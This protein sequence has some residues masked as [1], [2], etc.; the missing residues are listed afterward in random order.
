MVIL[1]LVHAPAARLIGAAL[2]ANGRVITSATALCFAASL[3]KERVDVVIVDPSV[4]PTRTA[5]R[6]GANPIV[7]SLS[8]AAAPPFIIYLSDGRA[9]L[10]LRAALV[11]LRPAMVAARGIDDQPERIRAMVD[12]AVASRT[13]EELVSRLDDR[14]ALVRATLGDALADAVRCPLECDSV[15]ALALA[16]GMS[17][18]ALSRELK[19]AG[20]ASARDWLAA[21]RVLRAHW[22]LRDPALRIRHLVAIM[23]YSSEEPLGNDVAAL[24][25]MTPSELRR[26]SRAELVTIVADRLAPTPLIANL[27]SAPVAD[28]P[29][30]AAG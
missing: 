19:D 17:C 13:A 18:R 4:E 30:A 3:E 11:R 2:A 14:L 7:R 25:G 29:I 21:G 23:G 15:A 5:S 22:E 24:T 1:T 20:L 16:A 10:P 8:R 12:S 27:P 28:M 6:V 26:L 9:S